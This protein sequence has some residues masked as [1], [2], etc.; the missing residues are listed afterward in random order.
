MLSSCTQDSYFGSFVKECK[1]FSIENNPIGIKS[2]IHSCIRCNEQQIKCIFFEHQENSHLNK[3]YNRLHHILSNIRLLESIR[4]FEENNE[5][6]IKG[7][8]DHFMINSFI[9]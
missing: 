4:L 3:F 6:H 2:I 7:I 1:H 5:H 8:T 9:L